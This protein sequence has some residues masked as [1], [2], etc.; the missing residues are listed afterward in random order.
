MGTDSRSTHS[1]PV[2]RY[3]AGCVERGSMPG[4]V[5][6]VESGDRTPSRGAVGVTVLGPE[7]EPVTE[8]TPFDLA[9]LTKPLATA[10]LLVL[11]EQAGDLDLESPASAYLP[12]LAGSPCGPRSLL[13]LATHTAGLPAWV[14]LYLEAADLD[15]YVESIAR[16][17]AAT[18]PG[19]TLYSDLGYIL[20]GAVLQRV[21]RC[22][23]D[24]LFETRVARPLGLGR[25]GFARRPGAFRDA[26]A[27]ER[28][29]AFER[30]LA[31]DAGKGFSWRREIPRGEVHD[32]NAHGLGGVAGHAGLF[33][34][35]EDV[36]RLCRAF[37]SPDALGLG[38][39]ARGR[40]LLPGPGSAGRTVGMV[41]AAHSESAK[42][43]LP[44]GAPGHTGFTGTSVWL[45][46]TSGAVFVLLTNR[47]HPR[48][49]E[50]GF[51][52][53]R[54]GFHEAAFRLAANPL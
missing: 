51:Q 43:V 1:D 32:A 47:V 31:G 18:A 25:I 30:T 9:S 24:A 53:V 6:S 42:G 49:P 45:E 46:P 23:L 44:A 38:D 17:P 50:S 40:L 48:V 5:W 16:R 3:V 11:L 29:N 33:G 36:A 37:S 15:G 28:G 13:E 35:V 10:V 26:A 8:D 4:A 39:R 19:Q 27:T 54:R 12:E 22:D 2:G 41:A 21:T 52:P 14:P 7:R 20:L 34:T